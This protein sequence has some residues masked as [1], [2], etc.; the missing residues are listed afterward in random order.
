MSRHKA[1]PVSQTPVTVCVESL[2]HEGRGVAHVEGKAVFIDGALPGETVRFVYSKRHKRHDEAKVQEVLTPS[3]QRVAARCEHFGVCGGCA[4]QHL[5]PEAQVQ[6]KQ[7]ILLDSL[8]HLGKLEPLNVLAPLTG[9]HW[10]YR[11]KARLGVKYVLKK[12]RLMVGFR[13]RSLSVVADLQSCAILHPAIGARLNELG[14]LIR[15]LDA[16]DH[17]AQIEVAVG[18]NGAAL[19]FRTMI[20]LEVADRARLTEFGRTNALQIY[21]QAGGPDSVTLLWPTTADLSYH[22][23]EYQLDLHFSPTDFTQINADINRALVHQVVELLDPGADDAVLD[24]FCGLGNFTLPLARRAGTVVGVEGDAGLIRRA[25]ENA[26]LNGIGNARFHVSDLAADVSNA[27]W[28][29]ARYDKLLLDPPRIGAL[30]LLPTIAKSDAR[31]IVYVSC[32]PA[33]LAR[34]AGILVHEHGYTLQSAGVV[35][36]FPHTAH[37]ESIALFER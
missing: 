31:R 33:T 18:D 9:P 24:L 35:D 14:E 6:A 32:N 37:V 17:I 23:P 21:L 5:E 13:E 11:R 2:S 26:R 16:Y 4:L 7:Q 36:M 1:K 34:D 30:S 27:P 3:P 15:G 28:R 22:L 12:Q 8:R 20:V 10:H 29:K 25:E 19:V